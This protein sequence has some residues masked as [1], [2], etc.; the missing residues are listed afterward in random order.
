MNPDHTSLALEGLHGVLTPTG[1]TRTSYAE[2]NRVRTGH[3]SRTRVPRLLRDRPGPHT[4]VQ[5]RRLTLDP[6]GTWSTRR[7]SPGSLNPCL[8]PPV[9][10]RRTPQLVFRISFLGTLNVRSV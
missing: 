4:R 7:L 5:S 10:V 1:P 3:S 2:E 6:E 9:L 8:G